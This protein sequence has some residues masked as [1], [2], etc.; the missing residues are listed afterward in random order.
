MFSII[1][2]VDS[3]FSFQYFDVSPLPLASVVSDEKL[4]NIIWVH[5]YVMRYFSLATYKIFPL[6]L[7]FGIL[8]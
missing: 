2:L 3:F 4:V 6:S 1:F 8:L 5:L 7:A